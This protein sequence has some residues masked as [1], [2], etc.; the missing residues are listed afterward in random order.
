MLKNSFNKLIT[1][2]IFMF[3]NVMVFLAKIIYNFY[4]DFSTD[5]FEDWSI[6]SNLVKYGVYAEFIDVGSTAYKLPIYP[7]FLSLFIYL[8]PKNASDVIIVIQHF[9]YFI[10]PLII[11]FISRILNKEKIGIITSYLFI[12]SPA[13]FFY[14]NVIEATNIFIPILLVWVFFY[15][16]IYKQYCPK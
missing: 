8:F 4:N 1:F 13:Y 16:K 11:I 6:A 5:Y 3:F 10:I 9:F 14:S 7:L 2:N 15:L 12:F